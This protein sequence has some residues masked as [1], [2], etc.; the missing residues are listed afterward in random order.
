MRHLLYFIF[1][2]C[3]FV[4]A[5]CQEDMYRLV[6]EIKCPEKVDKSIAGK[7]C[8]EYVNEGGMSSGPAGKPFDEIYRC[9][10]LLYS[11]DKRRAFIIENKEMQISQ[12]FILDIPKNPDPMPWTE[13]MY[14]NY[15]FS[16]WNSAS[17]NFMNGIYPRKREDIDKSV[18]YRIRYKL[19]K[20]PGF[21]YTVGMFRGE[22]YHMSIDEVVYG[23]SIE[24]IAKAY[25][26]TPQEFREI[27][28]LSPD[29][30]ELHEG[31][32]IIHPLCK[33]DQSTKDE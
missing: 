17:Y 20:H 31:D 4:F 2:F 30:V 14:P 16:G 12:V 15:F 29:V 5:G 24:N 25:D 23:D 9:Q 3:M 33:Y 8:V 28:K 18:A 32:T 10:E 7:F 11:G 22:K 13:W 21:K 26:M 6:V 27:S 1:A 19:L